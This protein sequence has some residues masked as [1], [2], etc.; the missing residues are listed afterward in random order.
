MANPNLKK[1]CPSLNPLGK[2]RDYDSADVMRP[3][4]EAY[5]Q[6][7]ID[8]KRPFTMAGLQLALGFASRDTMMHYAN[9]NRGEEIQELMAFA[10]LAVEEQLSEKLVRDEGQKVGIV[11]TL[12]NNFGW[13][14]QSE[15]ANNVTVNE[16]R[17]TVVDPKE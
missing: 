14:D 11:F 13:K 1:G 10:K 7:Q 9:G 15:V 8:E 2:P 3:V 6:R 17:R 16:I 12:K 4:V 5:F